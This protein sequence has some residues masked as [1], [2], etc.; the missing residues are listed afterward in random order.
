[1]K[2]REEIHVKIK[3]RKVAQAMKDAL[4]PEAQGAQ[5]NDRSKISKLELRGNRLSIEI[6]AEDLTALR[7]ST[8]SK[9]RWIGSLSSCLSSVKERKNKN[10]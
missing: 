1:M 7:A 2:I 6:S 9:L 10:F 3:E 8:D 5:I 4:L